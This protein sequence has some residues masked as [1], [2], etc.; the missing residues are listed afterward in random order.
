MIDVTD[1]MNTTL[2][3]IILAAGE[4]TRMRSSLPKILHPIGG[5]P[6]LQHV[7]D[8]ASELGCEHFHIVY[9]HGG[10]Q[11]RE[12]IQDDRIKWVHQDIHH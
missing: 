8:T 10:D 6:M 1:D 2:D 5:R 4:G 7:I 3:I 12:S 11:V 9:G